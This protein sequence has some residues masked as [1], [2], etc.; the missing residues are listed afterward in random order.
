MAKFAD[1]YGVLKNGSIMSAIFRRTNTRKKLP[2]MSL[3]NIK[4][5]YTIRFGKGQDMNS[6][7]VRLLKAW[8]AAG[9]HLK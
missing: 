6:A 2:E 3:F 1:I 4:K 9:T 5:V 7:A 8:L